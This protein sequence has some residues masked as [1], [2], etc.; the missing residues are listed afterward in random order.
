M[1]VFTYR[2]YCRG[3][4]AFALGALA[5]ASPLLF[6]VSCA[7]PPAPP[8]IPA[9]VVD[10]TPTP[11]PV[12]VPTP[13]PAPDPLTVDWPE[14]GKLAAGMTYDQVVAALAQ[15]PSKA[16]RAV[17]REAGVEAAS[18]RRPVGSEVF[19]AHLRFRSGRLETWIVR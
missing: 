7:T 14:I 19:F 10:P 4:A 12:P 13:E 18:W 1:K 16:L 11:V 15:Q 5:A 3:L 8:P 2:S 9:P 6:V 17:P